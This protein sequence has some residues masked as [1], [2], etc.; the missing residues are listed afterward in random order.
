MKI[1]RRRTAPTDAGQAPSLR[2]L[3][4][5]VVVLVHSE[6]E[7]NV[8]SVAR[9]AGNFG[10]ELRLVAS[11]CDVQCRDALKMAHPCENTLMQAQIWPTL[12]AA[13]AD[14]DFALATSGK[15]RGAVAAEPLSVHHARLLLPA[16][17]ARLALVFGNERTGL[18]VQ[19][20]NR[21]D[22]VV[23]LPTPGP[24]ASL[25]VAAAVAVALTLFAEAARGEPEPRA[26]AAVRAD[27]V[28]AF[29]SALDIRGFYADKARETLRP[30]LQELVGKMD[31]SARD[32]E[33]MQQLLSRLAQGPSV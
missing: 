16:P 2:P 27:L 3:T 21:C 6:G 14:I 17:L 24:V 28:Q 15:L 29:E 4:Q 33:L 25:N 11:R 32:V 13:L 10:A 7:Q 23:R 30:R 20:A 8:G 1:G 19:D 22:R 12:A 18:A 26:P 31:L 9:L 5:L